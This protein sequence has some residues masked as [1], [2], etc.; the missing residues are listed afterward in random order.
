MNMKR[1]L[2]ISIIAAAALSAASCAIEGSS[3]ANEAQKAYIESWM[4]VN[5][6]G[7][8]PTGI[9]I[10]ILDDT[11]GTGAAWTSDYTYVFVDYTVRSLDGTIVQTNSEKLNRQLGKYS[12]SECY[13]PIAW[14]IGENYCYAG[15]EE[16]LTGM[17]VGG[18]RQAVIPS[19]L[20]TT[21]RYSSAEEYLETSVDTSPLIYTLTLK[22]MTK[23]IKKHSLDV[24][25]KY[26]DSKFGAGASKDSTYYNNKDGLKEGFYFKSIKQP[27]DSIIPSGSTGY[28]WYIGRRLDGSVFDTNIADTAKVHNIYSPSRT[29]EPASVTFAETYTDI[30]FNESTAITGFQAAM[31]HMHAYE[32]ATA[33]FYYGLGYSGTAQTGIPAYSS[34]RFDLQLVD[35]Q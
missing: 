29:Y 4:E 32:E 20:L 25:S 15:V 26:I 30:K 5:H 2:T 18:T 34:L 3:E 14:A 12:L 1:F 16:I 6:P 24:L 9:G 11:P 8:K 10:Y 13:D 23:D 31:C 22:N 21:S 28:L 33:V 17:K 27:S 19:W 7:I 35:K